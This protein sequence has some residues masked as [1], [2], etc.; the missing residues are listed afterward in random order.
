MI[1]FD[2]LFHAVIHIFLTHHKEDG[3]DQRTSFEF[4]KGMGE[5]GFSGQKVELFLPSLHE[6]LA[7]ASGDNQCIGLHHST[8]KLHGMMECWNTGITGEPIFH[9]SIIPCLPAGR[10]YSQY[11]QNSLSIL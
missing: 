4:I 6:T 7:L 2:D 3:A 9:L 8:A 10:H 1:F 11:F 5:D